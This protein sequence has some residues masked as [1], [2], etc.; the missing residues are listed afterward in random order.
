MAQH[1]Q[2]L[3]VLVVDLDGTLIRSDM[4]FESFWSGFARDWR[5]PLWAIAGLARGRAALKARLAA[6]SPPDPAALPYEPAVLEHVRQWRAR[7]GQSALVTAA[8]QTLANAVANHLDL[9]DA[10]HGSDGAINLKG[11]AKA[12]WLRR[13][14][15]AGSYVYAGDSTADLPVWQT[16]AGAVT[17]GLRPGLRARVDALHPDAVHLAPPA[18]IFPAALRAMRPQQW[19]KNLLVFLPMLAAHQFGPHTLAQ[20]LVAFLAFSLVASS[21]YLLNDLLDI[22]SDRAHPRKRNRPLASGAL[23]LSHG[24]AMVPLLLAMGLGLGLVLQPL[25]LPV[26]LGYYLLTI[27]YSLWLKRKPI[28]D[29]CVLATLYTL[30]LAAGGAAMGIVPSVW[31]LSFSAFLFFA[32][33]AVKR[34][35]ELVDMAHRNQVEAAGRG[36][37]VSDLPV[38]TQM[39]TASGFVAVLVFMLYLNEPVTRDL[40]A[41]PMI[42]W[43]VCLLLLYWVARMILLAQ[44][45]QMD[46]DPVAFAVRDRVSQIVLLLFAAT[47]ALATLL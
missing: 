10:V 14:Y 11:P 24:M 26:L 31:L 16:A 12:E 35:A 28:L 40:Y 29:I 22:G 37:R 38:V 9:F 42:L 23:P 15:G 18:P 34:Q 5:T 32:L 17:V 46:D 3:P 41:N 19:V 21:V 33:A 7:G 43:A 47:F 6:I 45:G 4:L 25:F 27:A 13:T 39:A 36:Y 8:D 1:P 20:G 44:R 30:R 2:T